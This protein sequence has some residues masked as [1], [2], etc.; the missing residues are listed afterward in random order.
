[1]SKLRI[2]VTVDPEIE[3][4]LRGSAKVYGRSLSELIRICLVEFHESNPHRFSTF[5]KTRTERPER[6]RVVRKE[7]SKPES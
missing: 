5:D 2:T 3:D 4:W 6:W 1:M 7:K